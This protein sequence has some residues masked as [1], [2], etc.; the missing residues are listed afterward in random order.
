MFMG[1]RASF[2]QFGPPGAIAPR[3]VDAEQRFMLR[4]KSWRRQGV[5]MT[6]VNK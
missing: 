4:P 1:D 6:I 5:V 2:N 3:A